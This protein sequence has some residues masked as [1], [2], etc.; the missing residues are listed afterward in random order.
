M[1]LSSQTFGPIPTPCVAYNCST[2]PDYTFQ[3]GAVLSTIGLSDF[4][5]KVV[6]L[7]GS[8]TID[9]NA[10]FN[11]CTFITNSGDIVINQNVSLGLNSCF[12]Y[13]GS[14][15]SIKAL[16]NNRLFV[17][18][19]YFSYFNNAF[20][21][22]NP[23]LLSIYNNTFFIGVNGLKISNAN[24]ATMANCLIYSNYFYSNEYGIKAINCSS[25]VIGSYSLNSNSFEECVQ[26][27]ESI[28]SY[29]FAYKNK[30]IG[31]DLGV[32]QT[33]MFANI[34]GGSSSTNG[35]NFESCDPF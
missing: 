19:N 16:G 25:L 23:E 14:M 21:I 28:N 4:T 3:N 27:I 7:E 11:C 10:N 8:F 29:L 5:N 32:S 17:Q 20:E 35:I 9:I 18:N 31:C 13:C 30:F 34:D 12:F 22:E 1:R 24:S 2:P 33:N 26:G 6:K 15:G